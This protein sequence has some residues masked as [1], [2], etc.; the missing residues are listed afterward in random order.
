VF[1]LHNFRRREWLPAI[2]GAG[3]EIARRLGAFEAQH[4]HADEAGWADG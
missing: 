2:E 4:Q 3:A 1:D